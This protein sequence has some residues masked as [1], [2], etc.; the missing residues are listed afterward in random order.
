MDTC[1]LY[2]VSPIFPYVYSYSSLAQP[3]SMYHR[4]VQAKP[5]ETVYLELS[6]RLNKLNGGTAKSKNVYT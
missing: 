4:N 6:A 5:S 2:T 1:V 3:L